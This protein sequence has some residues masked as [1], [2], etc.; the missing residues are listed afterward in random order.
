MNTQYYV[1]KISNENLANLNKKLKQFEKESEKMMGCFLFFQV[2]FKIIFPFPLSRRLR[3]PFNINILNIFD[4][5][6]SGVLEKHER[7]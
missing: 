7:S 1:W 6:Y 2:I 3:A 5:Q 4:L